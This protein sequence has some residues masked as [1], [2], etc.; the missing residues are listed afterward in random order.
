MC[1]RVANSNL[2]AWHRDR[3]NT[4]SGCLCGVHVSFSLF[5]FISMFFV[6]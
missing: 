2:E 6:Q 5:S 3:L 1:Y 4:F